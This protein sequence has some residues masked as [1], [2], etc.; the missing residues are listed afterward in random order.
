MS[1]FGKNLIRTLDDLAD[2]DSSGGSTIFN[3]ESR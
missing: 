2:D 3:N 1:I